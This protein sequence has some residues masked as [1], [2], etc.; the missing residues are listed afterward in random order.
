MIFSL[1]LLFDWNYQDK[2]ML[3]A[4]VIEKGPF[5]KATTK[6]KAGVV[7]EKIDGKEI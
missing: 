2:G 3:I 1:G 7:I 5:D 6:V 4:E